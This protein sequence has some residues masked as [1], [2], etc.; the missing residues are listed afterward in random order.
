[1]SGFSIAQLYIYP[2]KSLGGM[3]VDRA[4]ITPAGSLD[5][6]REW[7]VTRPDGAML[8][9]G[10]IPSMTL[11][12]ATLDATTLTLRGA[13]GA[14]LAIERGHGGTTMTVTQYGHSLEGVDAGD[15]VAGWLGQ[16][17]HASCRLVRVGAEA[18]RWRGLNP[19][20]AV[21]LRSLLALN[22]R[23]IEQGDAP[24]EAERFRP[25]VV[26]DGDHGAFAEEAAATIGFDGAELV[27]REPCVRCELPNISRVDASRGKQPLKLIGGMARG[28]LTA[29]SASFGIYAMAQGEALRV[30]MNSR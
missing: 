9:Q 21:S 15:A 27:L 4:S 26:L 25:N 11:L 19:V 22:E 17:L 16:H 1:M 30:G 6:D 13:D 12:E 14:T 8:W 7:I 3:A 18:H 5:G 23:L 29:K 24:V 10:D 2:V 28:R 20:H